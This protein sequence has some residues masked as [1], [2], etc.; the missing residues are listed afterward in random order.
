LGG[1]AGL[2]DLLADDYEL[3]KRIAN[4]GHKL[5]ICPVP[6]ECRTEKQPAIAVWQ[7]QLRWARTIRVSRPVGY[8]FSIL[9]NGTLWPLLAAVT[10]TPLGSSICVSGLLLRMLGAVSSYRRLTGRSQWWV[11][12]LALMKDLA[13][14]ALWAFSFCGSEVIWRGQRFRVSR[15]GKLTPLA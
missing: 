5:V 6:V 10:G 4:A 2:S 15:G 13:Q 8:F 12:P 11:A 9:G 7:H 14:F 1:F 3:G